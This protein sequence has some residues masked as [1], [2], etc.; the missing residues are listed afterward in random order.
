M[1]QR[2]VLALLRVKQRIHSKRL[3]EVGTLLIEKCVRAL[4]E[5]I[6]HD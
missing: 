5:D 1:T 6:K 2:D 3:T 4:E